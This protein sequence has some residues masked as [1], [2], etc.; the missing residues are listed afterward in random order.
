MMMMMM[1]MM[2]IMVIILITMMMIMAIMMMMIIYDDDA[3]PLADV[4]LII[5]S[6]P[7]TVMMDWNWPIFCCDDDD[8]D[9]GSSNDDDIDGSDDWVKLWIEAVLDS[10]TI[11]CKT[12]NKVCNCMLLSLQS[13]C[14]LLFSCLKNWLSTDTKPTRSMRYKYVILPVPSSL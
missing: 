6:L 3:L 1:M 7:S 13:I 9:C 4:I 2:T 8:D 12:F 10:S 5:E 14:C 11:S